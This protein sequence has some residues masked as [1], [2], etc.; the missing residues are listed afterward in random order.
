MSKLSS[1]DLN[2]VVISRTA[3]IAFGI[4]DSQV[5]AISM[6][7]AGDSEYLV[8]SILYGGLLFTGTYTCIR[9]I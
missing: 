8:E 2:A 7:V 9:E 5:P 6:P 3:L 1:R 4:I